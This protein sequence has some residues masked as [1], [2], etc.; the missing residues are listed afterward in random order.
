VKEF[1]IIKSYF[2]SRSFQ[3]RDVQLG[4]G[5]DCAL[6]TVPEGQ[7]LV[8]TTDTLIEGVHFP[9]QTSGRAV[10]HKALAVNL[11]DLAAMGAEPAWISLSLSLPAYDETWLRDF[12][13]SL[14]ELTEYYSVQLIGGDTVQG[15]LSITITAQGF[16]PQGQAL[17][18]SKAKPGDW[19]YVTGT[20][21]D[22]GLG[23]SLVQADDQDIQID[24]ASTPIVQAPDLHHKNYLINRLN[25][26]TPRLLAGTTLRRIATSCIDLSDGI[27]S[28]L[29][30]ILFAS[31]VGATIDVE[32]LPLSEAML[33]TVGKEAGIR[34]ALTSGDDYELLFTIPEEQKGSLDVAFANCNVPATCIGRINGVPEKLELTAGEETYE[35]PKEG[36]QH[37]SQ[38]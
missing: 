19:I 15:H 4:I 35:L 11:S 37:F 8:T 28:D 36:F 2:L 22:A 26:P 3:R 32:S 1:E 12:S 29:K 38:A 10:A 18:R 14:Q 16:I 33:A 31:Q 6:T 34:Y 7:Q 17:M 27:K 25:C 30:H 23:L 21:G 9:K 13:L 20:L 24:L 5:D